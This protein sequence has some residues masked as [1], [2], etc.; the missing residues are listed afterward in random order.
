MRSNTG[1][2]AGLAA[3][4]PVASTGTRLGNNGRVEPAGVTTA[5]PARW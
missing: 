5:E 4:G 3:L 1:C 2:P